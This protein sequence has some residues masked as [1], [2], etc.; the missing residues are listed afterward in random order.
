MVK[1]IQSSSKGKRPLIAMKF[2][3][4]SV[5]NAERMQNVAE[6]LHDY[7][8]RAELLV[9]VSAMGG[10]TDMLVNAATQASLGVEKQWKGTR[11][12]LAHRHREVAD[13][14]LSA[15]EQ[16]TILPRLA[17]QM[18]HFEDLCSGF[19]LVREVT[20]RGMD[21]LS[22]LGE[23]MSATLMAAILRSRGLKAEAVDA[24]ELI[25]TN[26]NFGNASPLFDETNAK[27]RE[28]LASLRRAGTV[29]VVTGFRGATS[30]GVCTTLGRG[31][32]D[33]SATILAAALDA[34]EVWIWTDVDGVM[35]ADPRLVPAARILPE[36]SYQEAIELSFFGAKVLHPKT[37][38]PVMNKQ[39]P[40]WIKNSFNPSCPGT[41]IVASPSNGQRG[42]KA[43]TS[44]KDADLI[45]I[46]SRN[47]LTLP[48]LAARVF[49]GLALENVSTLT[50]TQSS[51]DNVLSFA[52]HH[53]DLPRVKTRLEKIFE[54][55][56]LHDYVGVLEVMSKIA[57]VVLVGEHMKGT[58]GIAGRAFGALGREG[59]NIIAIAQGSSEL[60]ISFAV[61]ASDMKAAVK[62]IHEE[63][64]L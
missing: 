23:V 2:G 17:E 44:V 13:K 8:Q 41:K 40:V 54:L 49:D 62:V 59:I 46:S 29:P 14:L 3:G 55:E 58:P 20:P 24:T 39:I 19:T 26:N 64:Q 15:S 18:K 56:M 1:D 10:V 5:G 11:E 27:T 57:V 48:Q 31:G 51:A 22:S 9:V 30:E 36:V 21:T 34:D 7:A 53:A 37:I 50:V 61:K 52:I 47:T 12:E 45:T 33:Y 38:Q 43:I 32:S 60:S 4:T 6:I 28:R 35:T 63:F 16:A 42:V 25:V